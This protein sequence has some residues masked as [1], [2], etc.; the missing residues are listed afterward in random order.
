MSILVA[1]PPVTI[2]LFAGAW[3]DR[4]DRRRIMIVVRLA[5]R[6]RGR[7]AR[8]GRARRARCRRSSSSRRSR[9]SSARSSRRPGWRSSRAPSPATGLLAANS[10]GQLTRMVAGV[11]GAT[12]TGV[13]AGT[14]GVVW[15]VFVVGRRHASWSRRCVVLGS[16]AGSGGPPR[17]PR[18]RSA[19]A[20]HGWRGPRRPAGDRPLGAAARR[21]RRR[22]RH[23]AR[24][25][26][27]QRPVHP[28]PRR[29]ARREPGLGGAAGGRPD[30]V[31]GPR[32][33]R[34]SPGS[35]R[36]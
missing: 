26:R 13:I 24:R 14:A 9:P 7:P 23:D 32:R 17:T 15:P 6:G 36:G 1:L 12:I 20:G 18:P 2:G 11:V 27:D 16:P 19:S 5:A 33:R 25:R 8:P 29:R 10:L 22:R 3:A 21:A 35:R 31:D 4:A 28:V 30:A 34:C